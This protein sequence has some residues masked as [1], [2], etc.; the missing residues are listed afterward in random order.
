MGKTT[1]A[2]D[3]VHRRPQLSP[4]W[5]AICGV[6]LP[7]FPSRNSIYFP[8]LLIQTGFKTHWDQQRSTRDTMWSKPWCQSLYSFLAPVF[9]MRLPPHKGVES[10]NEKSHGKR[11]SADRQ[12]SPPDRSEAILKPSSYVEPPND[13]SSSWPQPSDLRRTSRRLAQCWALARL[14]DF[15]PLA[16]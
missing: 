11:S 9:G 10:E 6:T 3:D 4:S 16:S 14:R 5:R 8:T 12:H 2:L 1:R 7:P 13:S 15:T